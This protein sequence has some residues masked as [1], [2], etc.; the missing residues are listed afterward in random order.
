M[1]NLKNLLCGLGVNETAV[2]G[3]YNGIYIYIYNCIYWKTHAL[4]YMNPYSRRTEVIFTLLIQRRK[5][6]NPQ[7]YNLL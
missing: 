6:H 2:N 5:L 3:H 4:I 1:V 7:L